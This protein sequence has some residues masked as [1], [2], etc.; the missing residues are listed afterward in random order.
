MSSSTPTLR[1]R[2]QAVVA[3]MQRHPKATHSIELVV[4][5]LMILLQ[6]WGADLVT[7]WR[8]WA[9]AMF[10]MFFGVALMLRLGATGAPG[11]L[12]GPSQTPKA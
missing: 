1:T 8:G 7:S 6:L 3:W 4:F 2:L 5:F 12:W 9:I 11:W 10:G